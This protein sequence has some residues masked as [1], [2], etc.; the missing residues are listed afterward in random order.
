MERLR[1]PTPG[2]GIH[3]CCE[4]Y[5]ANQIPKS[6]DILRDQIQAGLFPWA[7]PS[8]VTEEHPRPAPDISRA[9]FIAWIKDFYMLKEVKI[10]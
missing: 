3:D 6:E 9:R 1:A 2:I 8:V 4:I 7:I 10:P 5:R